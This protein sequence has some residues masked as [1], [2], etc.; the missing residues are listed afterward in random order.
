MQELKVIS[1][2]DTNKLQTFDAEAKDA[3]PSPSSEQPPPPPPSLVQEDDD[4][5]VGP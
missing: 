1:G 2:I 4:A 5:A 3:T